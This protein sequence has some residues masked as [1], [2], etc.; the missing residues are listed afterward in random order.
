MKTTAGW[1][2]SK[3]DREQSRFQKTVKKK[4]S[5][6]DRWREPRGHKEKKK[7]ER[8]GGIVRKHDVVMVS[9]TDI[10]SEKVDYALCW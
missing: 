8:E 2:V 5:L 6:W 3:K 4:D 9:F 7:M 1:E 10:S